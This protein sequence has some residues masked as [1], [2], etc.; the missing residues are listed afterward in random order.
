VEQ[1]FKYIVEGKNIM[2][3]CIAISKFAGISLTCLLTW[4]AGSMQA[5]LAD[6]ALKKVSAE[7]SKPIAQEYKGMDSHT[8]PKL[9][10]ADFQQLKKG[11]PQSEFLKRVGSPEADIGSGISIYVYPLNDGSKVWVGCTDTL[12]YVDHIL[13]D[14]SR[15]R[16]IP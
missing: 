3:K 4:T 8:Y 2:S 15:I 1:L 13:K 7:N 10:I 12:M 14:G 11:M 9:S 6:E 5:G 16:L